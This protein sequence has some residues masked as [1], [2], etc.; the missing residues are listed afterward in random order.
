AHGL[1]VMGGAACVVVRAD[2]DGYRLGVAG[3]GRG[4]AAADRASVG[5]AAAVRF[6]YT[7][8]FR[9]VEVV[10][11]VE[12]VEAVEGTVGG[13]AALGRGR[14]AEDASGH[15]GGAGLVFALQGAQVDADGRAIL[16]HRLGVIAG[17]GLVVDRADRDGHRVG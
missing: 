15:E 7:T 2:R 17:A 12:A 14:S 9:S 11:G 4:A 10:G 5:A 16:A 13:Q 8:L 3:Q 1:V 6:P